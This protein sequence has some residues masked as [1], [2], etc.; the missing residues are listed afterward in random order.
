M[1]VLVGCEFSGV[2]REAFKAL[3]HE[4]YSCDLIPTTQ[5]GDHYQ[6]D[7]RE[8]LNQDWDLAI[9]HPP[10][11]YLCGS[12]IHWN[13]R[14]FGRS[15]QTLESLR[16][17]EDLMHCNIPR[18]C[19]ENPVGLISTEIRPPDQVIQPWQFGDDA[20]KRTCL[21]LKGLPLLVPDPADR[22]YGR[23]VVINGKIVERWSNQTDSG[24]NKLGPSE[25]RG[26]DR[27]VTYPGIAKAM[28][29]QWGGSLLLRTE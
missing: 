19:I 24:Q 6:C 29:E 1:R 18:I 22:Y 25:T 9:F 13:D 11:T 2:V 20:S 15:R 12:G 23:C 14:I 3:G 26:A 5:P 28:A 16:F 27:A 17:V 10:C 7:V 21:W 8:L 4:A